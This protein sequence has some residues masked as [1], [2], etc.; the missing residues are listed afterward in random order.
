MVN[1]HE[2]PV[3]FDEFVKH[4]LQH[5]FSVERI[6]YPLSNEAPQARSLSRDHIADP[7]VL[8][9][10]F[11]YPSGDGL[12]VGEHT[13]YGL[14]TMLW[15]D[16]CGGLQVKR[17]SQW[18]DAPPI[19]DSFVCNVGDMLDRLTRGHYLS[20]AHRVRNASG[21]NR[22]SFAFFFDPNFQAEVRPIEGLQSQA[23]DD[24]HERWDRASVHEFR[25]TYGEYLLGKVAKVFP[26]LRKEVE[27]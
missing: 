19:P 16:S 22:L 3:R 4:I 7:L 2:Q 20:A 15:Q 17:G 27:K 10:I 14:L 11:N 5:I 25:G 12:G 23:A 9:R 1:R 24:C 13:D 21:R 26:Q 8:F 6:G 18:V